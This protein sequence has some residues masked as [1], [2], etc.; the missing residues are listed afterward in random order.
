MLDPHVLDLTR[1][2]LDLK[3]FRNKHAEEGDYET[4]IT[5]STVI[6]DGVSGRVVIV[7]LMLDD[8]CSEITDALHRIKYEHGYRTSGLNSTSRI[9]GYS[10]R[11]TI[12][13][14][15]CAATA[16]AYEHPQIHA[17]ITSYAK[18]VATYYRQ[19][20]PD[21]YVYHQQQTEKVLPEWTLEDSVFTSGIINKDNPLAYHFDTGNFKNVWSN[22]LV[23]KQQIEGGYLAV[24]EYNIGF[25]VAHN[26][27]LM[28]DGQN[29][30]H[31]VTPIHKMS[32]NAYRYSI[33]YY[34]LMQM[35]HC[36]PPQ[37][38]I[39]RIRKKRTDREEKRVNQ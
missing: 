38:E 17:L 10:P 18:R 34:S 36:L 24:P 37:D 2:E 26:T 20:N 23:F 6:R 14:D 29:I 1:C 13:K 9:F 39:R 30:L 5:A 28:F 15:Y 12:R 33:V 35:W 22:M 8:D 27:L 21:L 32:S 31:G 11:I 4:L 25:K 19:F 16:L 3:Q 7:Y